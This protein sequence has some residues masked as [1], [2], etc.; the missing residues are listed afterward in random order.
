MSGH[1][2]PVGWDG[3]LLSPSRKRS[4]VE[5]FLAASVF[6][7]VTEFGSY[8]SGSTHSFGSECLKSGLAEAHC[9][10]KGVVLY[11]GVSW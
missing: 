6:V 7:R 3:H 10:L 8:C 1:P 11:T 5:S 4:L 2:Q 9:P